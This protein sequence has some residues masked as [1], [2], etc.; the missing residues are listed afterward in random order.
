MNRKLKLLLLHLE[1][2]IQSGRQESG[3]R[4]TVLEKC[5]RKLAHAL[6]VKNVKK[7]KSAVDEISKVLLKDR[8]P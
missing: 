5:F 3:D 1:K 7:A 6:D 4:D 2:T 8:Q